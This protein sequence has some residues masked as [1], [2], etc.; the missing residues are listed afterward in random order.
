MYGQ[1][2]PGALKVWPYGGFF[3]S[4]GSALVPAGICLLQAYG[5]GKTSHATT[6]YSLPGKMLQGLGVGG[7]T[8]CDL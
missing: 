3:Y 2:L 1:E 4:T 7:R 6:R 8:Q 5:K